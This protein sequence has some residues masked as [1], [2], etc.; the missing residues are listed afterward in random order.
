MMCVPGLS[1]TSITWSTQSMKGVLPVGLP[2]PACRSATHHRILEDGSACTASR[3]PQRSPP[4]R[5]GFAWWMLNKEQLLIWPG[6][7]RGGDGRGGAGGAGGGGRPPT[8]ILAKSREPPSVSMMD[9]M[10][11]WPP[12]PPLGRSRTAPVAMSRSSYTATTRSLPT[13]TPR[14][15]RPPSAGAVRRCRRPCCEHTASSHLT[16]GKSGSVALTH[17]HGRN[18]MV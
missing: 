11:L 8:R 3:R 17:A 1:K 18:R 7:N 13:W 2:M 10:P 9:R 16:E 15:P 12:W 6:S 5:T 14:R 4:C